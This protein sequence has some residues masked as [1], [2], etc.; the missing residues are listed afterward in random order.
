MRL[1]DILK[2]NRRLLMRGSVTDPFSHPSYSKERSNELRHNMSEYV[3]RHAE[4]KE[5]LQIP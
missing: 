4:L 3:R 5:E 2:E 1:L